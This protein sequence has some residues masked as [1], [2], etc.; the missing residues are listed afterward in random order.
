M[1]TRQTLPRHDFK[2]HMPLSAGSTRPPSGND[3]AD[4]ML[5]L[6]CRSFGIEPSGARRIFYSDPF[7]DLGMKRILLA[8]QQAGVIVACLTLV[9]AAMRIAPDLTLPV[10]GIAGVCTDPEFRRQGHA[11]R[12]LRETA[13]DLSRSEERRVG[14]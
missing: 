5:S 9:P 8:A 12:L 13:A 7:F 10:C 3:E 11:A 6:M 2:H 14:T 1:R 4:A